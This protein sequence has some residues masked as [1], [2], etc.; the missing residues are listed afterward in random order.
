MD[1]GVNLITDQRDAI[2]SAKPNDGVDG[3]LGE[4]LASWVR[5]RVDEHDAR[6]ATSRDGLFE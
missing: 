6:A 4:S 2:L 3:R 5:W 1:I